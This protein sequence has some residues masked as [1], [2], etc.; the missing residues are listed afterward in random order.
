M[1]AVTIN[2][3]VHD[4]TP[5][6]AQ[7]PQQPPQAPQS[8]SFVS[9]QTPPEQFNQE[10]ENDNSGEQPE[11]TKEDSQPVSEEAHEQ[12]EGDNFSVSSPETSQGHTLT[13]AT[14]TNNRIKTYANLVKSSPSST[15]MGPQTQK[16]SMSP[17]RY[18][19]KFYVFEI[20]KSEINFLFN[21]IAS[22]N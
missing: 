4:D 2:G 14:S 9:E 1:G 8:H 3:S 17:V 13:T 15:G 6:M 10:T 11:Q 7:Q 20:Y 21:F 18:L 22:C 12:Q 5:L 16:L 19:K